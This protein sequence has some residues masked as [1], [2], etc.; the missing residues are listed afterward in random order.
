M[1]RKLFL[2]YIA[3]MQCKKSS[4]K[5]IIQSI[6]QHTPTFIQYFAKLKFTILNVIDFYVNSIERTTSK[7]N[8]TD[9]AIVILERNIKT[10]D[11][12]VMYLNIYDQYSGWK[13]PTYPTTCKNG[14]GLA[15]VL[16]S[17]I[18]S[19][20]LIDP[21]KIWIELFHSENV[22]ASNSQ[23][24]KRYYAYAKAITYPE[25]LLKNIEYT[26]RQS[27]WKV[28]WF[29]LKEMSDQKTHDIQILKTL[30]KREDDRMALRCAKDNA[31][32][33]LRAITSKNMDA[34]WL[35]TILTTTQLLADCSITTERAA[36]LLD[37]PAELLEY[38]RCKRFV[39]E[40]WDDYMLNVK[41]VLDY[42]SVQHE[43]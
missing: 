23:L 12:D 39:D 22:Y 38:F 31:V 14:Y 9:Q 42:K 25:H 37:V 6:T 41:I 26:Y 2:F 13:F 43:L 1:P 18:S 10:R 29:T 34:V 28:K 35:G 19:Q 20:F 15:S 7:M 17:V 4:K 11:V 40:N 5:F 16:E 36:T 27:K 8:V 21:E 33:E 32:N 24:Y 3:N 30:Q